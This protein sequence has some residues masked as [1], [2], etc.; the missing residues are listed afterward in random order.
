[1]EDSIKKIDPIND[2]YYNLMDL[3]EESGQKIDAVDLA[4]SPDETHLIFRNKID[5][6][7]WMLRIEE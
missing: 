5:G 3:A 2:I 4:L 7:L 6:Y 1:M